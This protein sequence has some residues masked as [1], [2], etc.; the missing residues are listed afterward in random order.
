MVRRGSRKS[1]ETCVPTS[2]PANAHTNR[3]T[4]EPTPDQPSLRNGVKRAAL[5]AGSATA[6]T[7]A[8]RSDVR[9]S[10]TAPATRTPSHTATAGTTTSATATTGTAARLAP[11]TAT[12]YSAPSTATTGA[13]THT[14]R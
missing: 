1:A 10:W 11:T 13:P 12:T 7:T 8:S 3:L 2:Q 5:A 4:A 6:T 14:P 9:P